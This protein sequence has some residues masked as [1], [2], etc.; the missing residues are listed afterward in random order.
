MGLSEVMVE[1]FSRQQA[2]TESMEEAELR[3]LIG[4]E[5]G[6]KRRL[7]LADHVGAPSITQFTT[8]H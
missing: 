5:A 6:K 3:S 8:F 4:V 7:G 1:K 2:K